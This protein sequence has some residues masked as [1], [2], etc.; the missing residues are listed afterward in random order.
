M[1]TTPAP[2]QTPLARITGNTTSALAGDEILFTTTAH[3]RA[4]VLAVPATGGRPSRR[5]RVRGR[6]AR[7]RV[8]ASPALAAVL[9][10]TGDS[11]FGARAFAGPPRG[12]LA[13]L[14]P[15]GGAFGAVTL[16]VD[17]D[18]IF[19]LEIARN[20]RQ[21]RIT[22]R[23]PGREPQPLPLTPEEALDAA[24]AG[25]LMAAAPLGEQN[26]N[27]EQP[28]TLSVRD[29]RTN[30]ERWRVP[31]PDRVDNLDLAPDGRAVA[32]IAGQ[33]IVE[34]AAGGAA[35]RMLS[36][37]K[38]TEPII[39][40]DGVVFVAEGRRDG[41]P[42][43]LV[44]V[45]PDGTRRTIGVP[46][47]RIEQ[48]V[49]DGRR[50][51]Y[52]AKG[53]LVVTDLA[54]PAAKALPKGPCR[55]TEVTFI[56]DGQPRVKRDRRIPIRLHC[57]A[58]PPPGCRGTAWLGGSEPGEFRTPKKRFLIPAGEDRRI[59]LRLNRRDYQWA[60]A[61]SRRGIGGVSAIVHA[62]TIEPDGR[63][64]HMADGHGFFPYPGTRARYVAEVSTRRYLARSPR[65][66]HRL[67]YRRP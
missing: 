67:G 25:D 44:H 33:R 46:S 37:G 13:P 49:S 26:E 38:T 21:A 30:Q 31:L 66:L 15:P 54:A 11:P 9:V 22:V 43:T 7:A 29:W 58:A 34:I 18:R 61:E 5:L 50:V 32:E 35:V 1:L 51:V 10:P 53:C 42:S 27:A 48:P 2:A 57:A 63:R 36:E 19:A 52:E 24:V 28:T 23:E 8:A 41:D 40:G 62:T 4:D 47:S 17:G 59:V 65:T 55:R 64:T 14:P 56:D 60:R 39:A 6:P 20:L 45:R 12:P 16:D 3:N